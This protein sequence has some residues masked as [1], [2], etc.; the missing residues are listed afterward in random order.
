MA[1]HKRRRYI[2]GA[3]KSAGGGKGAFSIRRPGAR[4]R[5]SKPYYPAALEEEAA[6]GFS[7][8]ETLGAGFPV[9]LALGGLVLFLYFAED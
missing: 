6:A 3:Y 8:N 7:I 4:R 5:R 1:D 2:S 9:L